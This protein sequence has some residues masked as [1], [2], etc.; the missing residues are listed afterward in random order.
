M[1]KARERER[2]W[3]VLER[4]RR[5]TNGGSETDEDREMMMMTFSEMDDAFFHAF[6]VG[7]V[8]NHRYRTR[9][10]VLASPRA[11]RFPTGA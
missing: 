9:K 4:P 11:G 2:R 7:I 5:D 8:R 3:F 6:F 10:R 1:N